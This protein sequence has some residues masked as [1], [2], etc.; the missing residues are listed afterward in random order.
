MNKPVPVDPDWLREQSEVPQRTASDIAAE[1]GLTPETVRR[2]L[3]RFG[4]APRPQ[5]FAGMPSH[6]RTYPDMPDDI[7][8]SVEG[9]RHG[10]LRL[11]RFQQIMGY[12]SLNKAT[13]G[14]GTHPCVPQ[15]R[16]DIVRESG[17]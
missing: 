8:R 3:I 15:L 1:L 9:P 6:A 10:R 7:R 11:R 17:A 12:P 4:I 2:N 16:F 14:L 13:Q 5:G